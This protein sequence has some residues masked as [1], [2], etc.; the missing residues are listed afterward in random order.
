MFGLFRASL[1]TPVDLRVLLALNKPL[2][3]LATQLVLC[4]E[5]LQQEQVVF[6]LS[7]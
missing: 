2:Y 1:T 5:L 3:K 6:T 4:F 7:A